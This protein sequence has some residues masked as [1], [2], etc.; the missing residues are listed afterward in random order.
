MTMAQDAEVVGPNFTQIAWAVVI[1]FFVVVICTA[2]IQSALV[3]WFIGPL[4]LRY[5][6]LLCFFSFAPAFFACPF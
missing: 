6:Q 3:Y 5:W 1:Y 2:L 4:R